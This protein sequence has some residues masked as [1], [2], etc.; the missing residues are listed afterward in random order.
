MLIYTYILI[1]NSGFNIDVHMGPKKIFPTPGGYIYMCVDCGSRCVCTCGV[2]VIWGLRISNPGW[3][4]LT[5]YVLCDVHCDYAHAH[6][7]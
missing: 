5:L 2:S 7:L 1:V 6:G 3:K 4:K